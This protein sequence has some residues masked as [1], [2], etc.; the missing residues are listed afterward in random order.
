MEGTNS[1]EAELSKNIEAKLATFVR[2]IMFI[3]HGETALQ[4]FGWLVAYAKFHKIPNPS[5]K[6]EISTSTEDRDPIWSP[7]PEWFKDFMIRNFSGKM[8]MKSN[9]RPE[10]EVPEWLKDFLRRNSSQEQVGTSKISN[11]DAQELLQPPAPLDGNGVP[12]K[13]R[14]VWSEEKDDQQKIISDCQSLTSKIMVDDKKR[15]RVDIDAVVVTQEILAKAE[16]ILDPQ[17]SG[18]EK[19][20]KKRKILNNESDSD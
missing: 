4:V 16:E 20:S 11:E 2:G 18:V 5:Y 14:W 9:V 15:Q 17:T 3:G 12:R 6:G 13:G 8:T 19:E 7:T 10:A 1:M